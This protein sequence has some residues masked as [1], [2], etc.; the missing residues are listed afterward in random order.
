MQT[1]QIFGAFLPMTMWPQLAHCQMQSPS[2]ENTFSSFTLP[3]SLAVTL[4]VSLLDCAYHA[5]LGCDLLEAFLVGFL[6]HTVIHVSPFIVL[7]RGGR[8][9]VA[10]C[11]LYVAALKIFEPQF[12]MLFLVACSL[13]EDVSYLFVAFFSCL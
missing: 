8:L 3:R 5:E 12:S 11:V 2:F 6:S 1:G 7:A 4:F 13:L 10:G 9:E